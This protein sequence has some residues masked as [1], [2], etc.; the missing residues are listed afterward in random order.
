VPLI[1]PVFRDLLDSCDKA[2]R[3]PVNRACR[4]HHFGI[5]PDNFALPAHQWERVTLLCAGMALK[6]GAGGEIETLLEVENGVCC[7][8]NPSLQVT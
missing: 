5:N 2:R 7:S 4:T 6:S 8:L 3:D 1:L